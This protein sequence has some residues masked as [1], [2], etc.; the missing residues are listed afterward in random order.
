MNEREV[1]KVGTGNKE[2]YPLPFDCGPKGW[3]ETA[4]LKLMHSPVIC[5]LHLSDIYIYI[6]MLL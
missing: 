2:T 5:S 4:V 1:G 6:F 3:E